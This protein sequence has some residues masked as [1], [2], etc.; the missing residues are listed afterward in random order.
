MK[1]R[2]MLYEQKVYTVQCV[3]NVLKSWQELCKY[4][5]TQSLN[6]PFGFAKKKKKKMIIALISRLQTQHV[7]HFFPSGFYHLYQNNIK[8]YRRAILNCCLLGADYNMPHI[9][10]TAYRRVSTA[11]YGPLVEQT[12]N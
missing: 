8:S 2:K 3:G 11:L 4:S 9:S 1:F 10:C 12:Y 7:T 5:Q 6:K